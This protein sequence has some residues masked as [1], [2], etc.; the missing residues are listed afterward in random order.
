[1]KSHHSFRQVFLYLVIALF[2]LAFIGFGIFL[3][4]RAF[5]L[6]LNINLILL[7]ILLIWMGLGYLTLMIGRYKIIELANSNSNLIIKKPFL[8]KSLKSELS[9]V[10]YCDFEYNLNWNTIKG[11]LIQFENGDVEQISLKEYKNSRDIVT[12]I[13]DSCKYDET[14]KEKFWTKELKI[15]LIIGFFIVLGF[16]TLK[17]L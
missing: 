15:F 11:I 12:L 2:I 5:N 17:I 14:I 10:R 8:G 16:I 9:K 3:I 7:G 4:Y 13:K 1:M 6:S